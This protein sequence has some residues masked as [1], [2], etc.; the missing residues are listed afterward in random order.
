MYPSDKSRIDAEKLRCIY[1]VHKEGGE[2]VLSIPYRPMSIDPDLVASFVIAVLLYE[3]NDLKSI[4]KEGYLVLIEEGKFIIGILMLD[5]VDNEK[6]YRIALQSI[7]NKF[8][9]EFQSTFE[10]WRGDVRSFRE[11]ALEVFSIF[12]YMSIDVGLIPQRVS[13]GNGRG[14]TAIPWNVGETYQ[15]VQTVLSFINGKRTVAQIVEA[16]GLPAA[17]TMA[18]LSMLLKYNWISLVQPLTDESVLIRLNAPSEKLKVAYG[19]QLT[20]ILDAI[21]GTRTFAEVCSS[22]PFDTTVV[23]AVVKQLIDR[24]IVGFV[25]K[26]QQI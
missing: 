23:R 20:V 8:E 22:V 21:N 25:T 9:I 18:I 6:S 7:V 5:R 26:Q 3:N 15:K 10:N 2:P 12:P 4:V 16:T 13:L 1:I 24:E 17:N 11:F 19:D 14:N